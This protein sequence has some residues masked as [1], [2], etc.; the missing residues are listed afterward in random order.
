MRRVLFFVLAVL[1]AARAQVNPGQNSMRRPMPA[2]EIDMDSG[3]P[4]G[5]YGGQRKQVAE[6]DF[7][8]VSD[9]SVPRRARKEFAKAS[10]SLAK[11]NWPQARDRLNKAILFYP[12]YAG[13]YN[14]L[15][16]A[17]AHLGDAGLERQALEKAIALNSHL[18]LAY[19]NFGRMDLDR[20]NL[21]EAITELKTAAALSPKDPNG[22]ILL[23]YCQYLQ[24]H[25]DEAIAASNEAHNLSAPHSLA[26]RVA[27]LAFEQKKQ[28]DHAATELILFL[29]EE[30]PGPA[31]E[32]ARNELQI[33]KAAQ[34]KARMSD[35]NSRMR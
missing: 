5:T 15:A 16:V 17:Y 28:F 33:V 3:P 20:G 11:E 26:H 10:D 32:R 27:A 23:G 35:F 2:I 8:S 29:Q 18:A 25:F 21:P 13:A 31:A 7:V 19:L 12:S 34:R 22:F 14:N 24:K 1:G 4:N 30:P 6:K 9:L